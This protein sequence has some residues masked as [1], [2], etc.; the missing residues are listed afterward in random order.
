MKGYVAN[1]GARWYAVIYDGLDPVT[2]R[3][4]RSWHPA[5]TDRADARRLATRLAAEVN[6]RSAQSRGLSFGAYLTSRW[7]P[8]RRIALRPST[9]DGYRRKIERQILP[10]LGAIALRRLRPE[11][12]EGLYDT[13]LHPADGGRPLAPKTVLEVHLIIRRAWATPSARVWCPATSR[14]SRPRPSSGPSPS[15]SNVRGARPSYERSWSPRPDIGSFLRSGS[16]P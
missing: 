3:E 8:A 1:K 2:G 5:G 11:D 6:G 15:P 14:S 9:Y 7:L 10:R 16:P 4:R 13:M 12:L